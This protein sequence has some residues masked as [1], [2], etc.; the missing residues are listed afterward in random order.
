M[1]EGSCCINSI[2]RLFRS[3]A[4][5]PAFSCEL[6]RVPTQYLWSKGNPSIPISQYFLTYAPTPRCF[7]PHSFVPSRI[8][9]RSG[10]S[11]QPGEGREV[12][13]EEALRTFCWMS[14]IT[15]SYLPLPSSSF[16]LSPIWPSF[17]T[18]GYKLSAV[19]H[20]R[21]HCGRAMR[22]HH[23]GAV[24]ARGQSDR[25]WGQESKEQDAST[26]VPRH[27]PQHLLPEQ[28]TNLRKAAYSFNTRV[29]WDHLLW[30]GRN[31]EGSGITVTD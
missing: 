9:P 3:L 28:C 29:S 2:G 23:Q 15:P 1:W 4:V 8:L 18:L 22:Q 17:T 31:A 26:S 24:R 30:Y 21:E 25:G 16:H 13:S 19:F 20:V 11:Y 14:A 12:V 10:L 27:S 5:Q 7:L 6:S